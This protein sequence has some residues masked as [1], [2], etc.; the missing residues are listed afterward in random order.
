MKNKR[1]MTLF[2]LLLCGLSAR[3]DVLVLADGDSISGQVLR[4]SEGVLVFRTKLKGQM[5]APMD[6]IRQLNTDLPL[7][8][9]LKDPTADAYGKLSSVG[10]KPHLL[11]LAGGDPVPIDLA[12]IVEANPIPT[13]AEPEPDVDKLPKLDIETGVMSRTGALDYTDVYTRIGLNMETPRLGFKMESLAQRADPD[14]FPRYFTSESTLSGKGDS[15]WQPTA[16]L[17]IERDTTNALDLRT[18]FTLGVNYDFQT[19]PNTA[20]GSMLGIN[21]T[22]ENWDAEKLE[23]GRG[24][25]HREHN[26]NLKLG[27]RYNKALSASAA[28][29]GNLAILPGLNDL[30]TFR[31]KSTATLQKNLTEHLHLRLDLSL[32]YNSD[33]AFA[34][35]ELWGAGF[36]AGVGWDF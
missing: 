24:Y 15:P 35:L 26:L 18:D 33:P 12:R 27:L 31:A 19:Q 23:W 4:I 2:L 1:L 22:Y 34:G 36:G 32:D 13:S 14:E 11:P 16:Q 5:M 8:L 10:E 21:Y 9:T 29:N 25:S 30:G 17:G 28:L 7:M 20:L 6:T 3:A